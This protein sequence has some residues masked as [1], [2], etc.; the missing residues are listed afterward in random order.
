MY[1]RPSGYQFRPIFGLLWRACADFVTGLTNRAVPSVASCCP[2]F[3]G[4]PSRKSHAVAANGVCG[5]SAEAAGPACDTPFDGGVRFL[6]AAGLGP[7]PITA[8]T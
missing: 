8:A 1:G 2:A 3:L 5:S 6:F 7:C 4:L